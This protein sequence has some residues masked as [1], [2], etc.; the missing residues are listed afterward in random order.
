MH[1]QN[2]GFSQKQNSLPCLWLFLT[3]FVCTYYVA[4][5]NNLLFRPFNV[6]QCV[7]QI[8]RMSG[9]CFLSNYVKTNK[10]SNQ[11]ASINALLLVLWVVL[12]TIFSFYFQTSR[13]FHC[14]EK[15]DSLSI[16]KFFQKITLHEGVPATNLL[17]KNFVKMKSRTNMK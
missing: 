13:F 2:W 10:Q 15:K 7:Q 9:L 14:N 8:P 4:H 3:E 12:L 5:K 1:C 11:E 16:G 17:Y 6:L